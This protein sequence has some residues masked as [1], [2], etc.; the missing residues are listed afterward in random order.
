MNILQASTLSFVVGALV[1]ILEITAARLVA[2]LLG[3]TLYTWSAIMGTVLAGLSAGAYVGGRMI[4][5]NPSLTTL[6]RACVGSGASV[7]VLPILAQGVK[8]LVLHPMPTPLLTLLVTMLLFFIP[9]GFLG[10]IQPMILRLSIS[11]TDILGKSYG[12]L[13][14]FWSIGGIV[15]ALCTGYGLVPFFGTE[16]I[17]Y[18]I[19][20]VLFMSGWILGRKHVAL[21]GTIVASLCLLMVSPAYGP[22]VL[23]AKETPYYLSVVAQA[24]LVHF[25]ESKI[26]FLDMGSHS[27]VRGTS[28]APLYTDITR[29]FTQALPESSQTLFLGGGAYVM[30]SDLARTPGTSVT[31]YE[32]DP[33]VPSIA[34]QYFSPDPRINTLIGDARVL[35]R[36][37]AHQYDLIVGDS[38][39]SFLSIPWHLLTKEFHDE[40]AEHLTPKGVYAVNI[41]SAVEGDKSILFRSVVRTLQ[42][43]FPYLT[44]YHFGG[45]AKTQ[46]NIMILASRQSLDEWIELGKD[47]Q[48][49]P[50]KSLVEAYRIKN[51]PSQD[52][53]MLTDSYAPTDTLLS[54]MIGGTLRQSILMYQQFTR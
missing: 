23:Y 41:V 49:L 25:G 16:K 22:R 39:Q 14:A 42:E 3:S 27:V 8:T 1:M 47:T 6:Y 40:I 43:T 9:S 50:G 11:T 38:F 32:L 17:I 26:L 19:S 12:G 30:P 2:P 52:G 54:S 37:D 10:S 34:K 15:G 48:I 35:L 45:D 31:V 33:E 7:F 29:L 5:Q 20:V 36:R 13:S 46:Q 51:M 28:T 24:N 44:A 4:D 53:V 21:L 18:G